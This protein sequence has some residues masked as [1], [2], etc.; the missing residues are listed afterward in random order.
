MEGNLAHDVFISHSSKDKVMADAICA[1]LEA[2]GIR[3]WIAPRDIEP[4]EEWTKTIVDAITSCKIFLLVFSDNANNSSQII[5]EV[6]CATSDEKTIIPFRMEDVKPTGSMKYYLGSLHWLDAITPPM[7]KQIESLADYIAHIL[8]FPKQE[9][10][11][12]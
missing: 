4:G 8:G 1:G 11:E 5:K 7:E 9:N 12:Q 10:F 2:R 6:D 3:C